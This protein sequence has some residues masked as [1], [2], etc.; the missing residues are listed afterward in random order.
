MAKVV[1]LPSRKQYEMLNADISAIV[2]NVPYPKSPR[3]RERKY[4]IDQLKVGD[5]FT[6]KKGNAATSARLSAV[7]YK[8]THTGWNY[9]TRVEGDRVRIWRIKYMATNIP[10]DVFKLIEMKS[11]EECWP[12]SG[13]W[14]G[15]SEDRRPYFQ[16]QGRRT[17]AY[18][19]VYELVNGAIPDGQMVLH[20]CD[21]GGWPVGCCN[22]HHLRLGLQAD[23]SK[24]MTD[25]QRHGLPHMVVRAI[26]RL[27]EQG[28]TQQ[29][30]AER[31]GLTREAVSA[32]ATQRAYST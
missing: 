2:S 15:R 13:A 24:D 21:Q 14:G 9:M 5:S 27:L 29:V 31:Y 6:V 4:P 17:M 11:S 16:A 23:N 25:R 8:K 20:S 30:I 22:P 26:R 18:R 28:E 3:G 10:H 12:Y 19:W 1:K 7:H 32:I